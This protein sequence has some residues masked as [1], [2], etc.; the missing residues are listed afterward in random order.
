MKTLGS[1]IDK[2]YW[3]GAEFLDQLISQ[4]EINEHL[5]YWHLQINRTWW[6]L[7][8]IFKQNFL[9][10]FSLFIFGWNSID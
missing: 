10:D 9:C 6:K 1:E 7:E 3:T 2:M 5:K 4:I 8:T